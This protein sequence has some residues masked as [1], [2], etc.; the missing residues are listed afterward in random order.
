M[1][2]LESAHGDPAARLH[3]GWNFLN[4]DGCTFARLAAVVE[5]VR[6]TASGKR[7][8]L[9]VRRRSTDGKGHDRE[10]LNPS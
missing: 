9:G 7:G 6:S 8:H 5:V 2:G 3:C 1:I 10:L 4:R